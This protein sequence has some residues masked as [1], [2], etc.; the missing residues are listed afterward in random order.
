MAKGQDRDVI[1]KVNVPKT[2]QNITYGTLLDQDKAAREKWQT[3][4]TARN[5]KTNPLQSA[6]LGPNN[7]I[8]P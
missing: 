5:S 6:I 8:Q 7:A 3:A 2:K 4:R 1:G